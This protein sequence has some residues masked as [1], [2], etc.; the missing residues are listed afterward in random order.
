MY[1]VLVRIGAFEV[2]SFG[3]LVAVGA[4]VGLWLFGRELRR[5]GLPETAL[6]AAVLGL[7]CGFAGAKILYAAEH[8]GEEPLA[9]LL[10]SRS[11]ASWF[12]GL[13]GGLGGALVVMRARRLPLMAVLSAATPALALGHAIG[14]VGCFLVGDDYG[15]PTS[16]PWGVAFPLGLPPTLERVH[17]TQV[18]E[19][20]PLV[21]LA[22]LLVR[23]RR[24]GVADRVVLGRYFV[25]AGGL[26]FLL[27]FV[28]INKV[29]ALGLTTAQWVALALVVTG[30]VLIKPQQAGESWF[31]VRGG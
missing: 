21:V 15:R 4:L 24:R 2:T 9:A 20:I 3:V 11:G 31:R 10:L 29:V 19:M 5:S 27:E 28:R 18:Y 13:L 8:Y 30:A 12:G 16:L 7:L 14:R 6:D 25:A 26:R 22:W 17:P 23:W 1:P